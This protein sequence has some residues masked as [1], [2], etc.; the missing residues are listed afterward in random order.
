MRKKTMPQHAITD[1]QI[2]NCFDVILELR[3]HLKRSE[4]VGMV[5][6]MEQEG[7]KLAFIDDQDKV[8]AVAGYSISTSL[9]M[10]KNLYVADLITTHTARS[11]GYGAQL[12]SWLKDQAIDSG[13]LF[14]HLDSGTHRGEAHKFYFSQGFT[15]SSYHFSQRLI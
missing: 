10:G 14:Y 2:E 15:I 4:F 1:Q 12:L 7:Y 8:I 11:K 6:A 13:C 9:F 5:R 3:P